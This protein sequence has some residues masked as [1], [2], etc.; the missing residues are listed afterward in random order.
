V[1][2]GPVTVR[3]EILRGGQVVAVGQAPL[4]AVPTAEE[5]A[6]LGSPGAP[7]RLRVALDARAPGRLEPGTTLPFLVTFTEV[8]PDLVDLEVRVVAVAEPGGQR[9]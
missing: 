5:M 4:G 3:A 9:G 6:A 7:E 2:L 8:P 1:A